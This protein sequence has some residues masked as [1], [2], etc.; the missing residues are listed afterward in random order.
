MSRLVATSYKTNDKATTALITWY[1]K[2]EE[3]N[4][5][6]RRN[7]CQWSEFYITMQR[8][9]PSGSP[10]WWW[11]SSGSSTSS[12]WRSRDELLRSRWQSRWAISWHNRTR[13]NNQIKTVKRRGKAI[14]KTKRSHAP[15]HTRQW[16]VE[17]CSP[18]TS[19]LLFSSDVVIWSATNQRCSFITRTLGG[20]WTTPVP[21]QR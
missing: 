14:N 2:K 6:R 10:C 8:S 18:H 4:R 3:R 12:R 15:L 16:Q 11:S 1:W 9:R 7:T 19:E 17:P 20:S 21:E 5:S 13:E